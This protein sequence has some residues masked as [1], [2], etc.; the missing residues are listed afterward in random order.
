MGQIAVDA[1]VAPPPSLAHKDDALFKSVN[2]ALAF[3]MNFTH[4]TIKRSGVVK[5]M[6]GGGTGRGLAGLD[7]AAQAG[8]IKQALEA[9]PSVYAHVLIARFAPQSE[10]C[11]C[12]RWCCRGWRETQE[13]HGSIDWLTEHIFE[14]GLTGNIAH[15]KFRR[16]VVAR[17]FGSKISFLEIARECGVDRDTASALNAKIVDYFRGPK[18]LKKGGTEEGT[19][20][21]VEWRARTEFEAKLDQAGM[22]E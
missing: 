10:P 4:G 2:H 8:M 9:L 13:W 12:K 15:I 14:I 22:L 5:M 3:A 1:G 16:S 19:R 18:W 17:Y 20:Q 7:G 6:G 21:G 11:T